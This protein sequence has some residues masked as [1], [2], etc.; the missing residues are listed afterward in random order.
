M[1][2][3][4]IEP[5][6]PIHKIYLIYSGWAFRYRLLRDG[7]KQIINFALPGDYLG[8]SFSQS[9]GMRF[10]ATAVTDL[11]VGIVSY[12]SFTRAFGERPDLAIQAASVIEREAILVEEALVAVGKLTARQRIAWL[13]VDICRRWRDAVAS[14]DGLQDFPFTQ[15][16]IADALGLSLVHVNKSLRALKLVGLIKIEG[17]KIRPVDEARLMRFSEGQHV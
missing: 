2:S 10:G 4:F 5:G 15:N 17:G 3:D 16:H 6:Q 8:V 12:A 14:E 13:I 9:D 1:S 7:R 11:E